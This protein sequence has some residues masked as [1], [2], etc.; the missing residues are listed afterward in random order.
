MTAIDL[1]EAFLRISEELGEKAGIGMAHN[2]IG[3]VY[4]QKGEYAKA[5]QSFEKYLSI[6][7]DLGDKRG[8]AI[9][10]GNLGEIYANQFE[11]KKAEELFKK[12]LKISEELGDRRGI[13]SSSYNLGVVAVETDD[14]KNAVKYLTSALDIFT[15][16]GNKMAMGNIFNG[17]AYLRLKEGKPGVALEMAQSALQAGEET[18]SAELRAQSFL[19]LGRIR[20][21][22]NADLKKA[23][24]SFGQAIKIAQGLKNKKLLADIYLEYSFFLKSAKRSKEAAKAARQA[25]SLYRELRLLR[26]IG[27]IP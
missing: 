17:F 24:D 18:G 20:G 9:A 13:G 7:Q 27:K 16:I 15:A 8:I 11:Y 26:K 21:Y 10:C 14:L 22:E 1:Y 23:D 19:N 4:F 25:Q 12:S 3:I 5:V 2:N 6:S